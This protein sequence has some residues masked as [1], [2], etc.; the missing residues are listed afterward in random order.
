MAVV[1]GQ[2]G[3]VTILGIRLE[4]KPCSPK[5]IAKVIGELQRR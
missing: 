5:K 1:Q 3:F 4:C 2:P